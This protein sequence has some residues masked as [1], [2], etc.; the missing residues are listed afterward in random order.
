MSTNGHPAKPPIRCAIYTRKSTS[1]GLEQEFTSLDA[2]REAC[3]N[4]IASQKGEG[5]VAVPELYDD[6][7]FTGANIDRPA[8]QKLLT[9]IREGRIDCV[10]VYKV[11]RLSRSLLDFTRVLGLFEQHEVAF[12]SVTQAFNTTSSMG[13]L[14]LNI[15][16]SFAQFERELISER[17]KDKMAAARKKGKWVGGAPILGYDVDPPTKRL[18]INDQEATLVRQIFERYLTE[19]SLLRVTKWLNAQGFT[20]KRYVT[21]KG[22]VLG[23][24]A[25]KITHVQALLKNVLYTGQVAYGG[26]LYPAQHDPI[27]SEPL[28]AQAQTIL[29]ENRV[30][31]HAPTNT[32][33]CGLLAGRLVCH[34]C[35]CAMIHTYTAKAHRRYRYYVCTDAQKRGYDGCPTRSVNAHAMEEAVIT[36]LRQLAQEPQRQAEALAAL[37]TAL[38]TQRATLEEQISQVERGIREG[39][40]E[41]ER[42]KQAINVG[43]GDRQALQGGLKRLSTALEDHERA[44][45]DRRIALASTHEQ[46]VAQQE[47]QEALVV[48]APATWDTLVPQ[49]KRRVLERLL[50]R[51]EYHGQTKLLTLTLS[52]KGVQSLRAELQGTSAGEAPPKGQ[53]ATMRFEFPVELKRVNLRTLKRSAHTP[54]PLPGVLRSLVVGHQLQRSLKEGHAGSL[55]QLGRWLNLTPARVSQLMRLIQLAPDI[56][57]EILLSPDPERI[58]VTEQHVRQIASEFDWGK[59]RIRWQALLKG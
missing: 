39:K 27:I 50:D 33:G 51:V 44:A 17:T 41:I 34:A 29:A 58:T 30:T 48:T 23:G 40:A 53:A 31:R 21:R 55:T 47:L 54:T 13:R 42:V 28:F 12:V 46:Q 59:Q 15:L 9:D 57:E 24:I 43:N 11:D 16:L 3:Q 10:V 32:K 25:F 36:C 22:R 52:A 6:G 38:Q 37:T 8:L 14:T 45:S 4:Y 18:L 26:Q 49:L 35:Q 5:W 19:R 56:Q 20:S 7:G 1:E 2:Q